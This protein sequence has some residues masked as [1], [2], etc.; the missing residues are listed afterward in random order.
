MGNATAGDA[1]LYAKVRLD[2][3][4]LKVAPAATGLQGVLPIGLKVVTDGTAMLVVGSDN[5]L[6]AKSNAS[7]SIWRAGYTALDSFQ[8][9]ITDIDQTPDGLILGVSFNNTGR[10]VTKRWPLQAESWSLDAG[11]FTAKRVK[12]LSNGAVIG[13]A[14]NGDLGIGIAGAVVDPWT[15]SFLL[16]RQ[17]ERSPALPIIRDLEQLQN[18]SFVLLKADGRLYIRLALSDQGSDLQLADSFTGVVAI[19]AFYRAPSRPPPPLTSELPAA[20]CCCL[21]L[22]LLRDGCTCEL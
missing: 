17:A 18:G 10:L 1:N 11:S 6:Y 12:A 16:L 20:C 8:C 19:S 21:L 14:A 3:P 2:T 7:V 9:C 5:T 22:L 13:V 4:W 15:S